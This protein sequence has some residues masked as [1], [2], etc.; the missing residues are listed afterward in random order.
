MRV[1]KGLLTN[2]IEEY[3]NGNSIAKSE[4]YP[5]RNY[6]A[7]VEHVARLSYLN[8]DY[9]L[10]FRGQGHD[11]RN[12]AGA[13]TIYPKIYRGEYVSRDQLELSFSV[14]DSAASNLCEALYNNNIES[15]N[16][17]K[18]RKYIQWSILQHYEVCPTP[19]LDITQSL[20]VACSFAY[21]SSEDGEPYVF[22]LGLPYYTNR[23]SLNTEHD[24][25]NVRLLSICP[26]EALRPYYQE[27]FVAGTDEVTTNFDSKTELDFNNRLIAKFQLIGGMDKFWGN[28][29]HPYSKSVLFPVNDRFLEICN[30][31]GTKIDKGPSPLRIGAFLEQWTELESW[32]MGI[33]RS[34][35][36]HKKIYSVRNAIQYLH[37]IEVLDTSTVELLERM[38]RTRNRVV[39]RPK[40]A[41]IAD[42]IDSTVQLRRILEDIRIIE[43]TKSKMSDKHDV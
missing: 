5:V 23:I 24:L 28:E 27:G 37:N 10:F 3:I 42:V 40:E 20:R 36:G 19:L 6:R 39:H 1:I 15:Y 43:K 22:V 33:A 13:T 2:E 35:A 18:R 12:K 26:P 9:L 21:M 16:D 32:I 25:V 8:K 38:R 30:S 7:L 14:L 4:A 11:H 31:I 29:F 41:K 34:R 17:V